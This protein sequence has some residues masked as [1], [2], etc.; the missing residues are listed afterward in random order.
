MS[1]QTLLPHFAS[2]PQTSI[3]PEYAKFKDVSSQNIVVARDKVK[4]VPSSG[5][6]YNVGGTAGNASQMSFLISDSSRFADLS[7]AT[8]NFNYTLARTDTPTGA[9]QT[10]LTLPSDNAC[11]LFSRVQIKCGGVLLEDIVNANTAFNS[12]MH[13]NMNHDYYSNVFDQLCGS[14]VYNLNYGPY[15]NSLKDLTSR[16]KSHEQTAYVCTKSATAGSGAR[17]TTK[18]S[19]SIPMGFLSGFFQQL[20]YLPLCLTNSLEVILYFDN[21]TNSHYSVEASATQ[22]GAGGLSYSLDS[23]GI[24]V[25]MLEMNSQYCQLLKSIAYQDEQG[26]SL[27]FDT[28]QS[29]QVN[30]TGNNSAVQSNKSLVF[31]KASPMVRTVL[32]T[33]TPSDTTT[34]ANNWIGN[35]S[36]LGVFA[37]VNNGN[38]GV[39]LSIGS[40][41][42]PL[43]GDTEHNAGT[44]N[45]LKNGDQQNVITGG[46]QTTASYA[47]KMW[48]L[49]NGTAGGIVSD[50]ELSNFVFGFGLDK[51]LTNE[52]QIDG[53]DSSALGSSFNIQVN[54]A[55]GSYGGQMTLN[56]FIHYTR[57]LALRGG[58]LSVSG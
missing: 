58:V 27:P 34:P 14:Y 33:K 5:Q 24:T 1:A 21:I 40:M 7:T 46:I 2:L 43:Y 10:A 38:A 6:S 12:R 50:L 13:C 16:F 26:I 15:G 11:S 48:D 28:V 47:G 25:D 52:C 39:R 44:Y 30:Y 29:F 8:L 42:V 22:P 57:I 49:A 45:L 17:A 36:H 20:K 3:I 19:F 4:Y 31:N 9:A 37:G 55:N 51:T 35:L 18:R 32:C 56:I 41:Y 23:V 54:E 53:L